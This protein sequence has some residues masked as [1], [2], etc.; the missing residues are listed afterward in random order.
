MPKRNY[1]SEELILSRTTEMD[2]GCWEW[3]GPY[4]SSGY[5]SVE[6]AGKTYGTHRIA[7]HLW[8]GFELTSLLSV[9]HRCDNPP[10]CNPAHLFVATHRE[11]M[12]DCKRKGRRPDLKGEC[13]PKAIL[14]EA[15]VHLIRALR[16]AGW[17]PR[18]IAPIFDIKRARISDIAAKRIWR[19]I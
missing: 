17:A 6:V 8:L 5:G 12:Q 2:S 15:D 7:A 4:N 18:E 16:K 3:Q 9:C 11:N 10:C 19:H 1:I 13:H 14:S